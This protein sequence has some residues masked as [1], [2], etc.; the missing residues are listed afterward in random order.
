V[1]ADC[2]LID[3]T[4][5][6]VDQSM[7]NPTEVGIEK[8][9]S[10]TVTDD[11][12]PDNHKTHPD[13]FLLSSSMIMTGCG[14][15]LVCSVGENTRLARARQPQDLVIKEQQTFFEERLESL[16]KAI[17]QWATIVTILI[18]LTQVLYLMIKIMLNGE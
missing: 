4:N 17:T 5:I 2:V 8:E 10:Y 1:P 13:P 6:T 16:S 11:E 3:E 18:I 14:K 15:A 7:Y 9:M 12:E